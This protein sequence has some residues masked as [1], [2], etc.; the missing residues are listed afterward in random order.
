[1]SDPH[2]SDDN[3]DFP[4]TNQISRFKLSDIIRR[5]LDIQGKI[6]IGGLLISGDLTWRGTHD[7]Y[8]WAREFIDDIM[9]WA[10]LTPGEVLVCPGNHDLAFSHEPWTKGTPATELGEASLAEYTHF[11]ENLGDYPLDVRTLERYEFLA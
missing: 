2:F 1:V 5:D 6:N 3:H 9:S 7:E 4:R 10:K 11:Y 8:K